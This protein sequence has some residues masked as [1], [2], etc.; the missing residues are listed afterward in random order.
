[1]NNLEYL[2]ITKTKFSSEFLCTFLGGLTNLTVL[3][4]RNCKISDRVVEIITEN[5]FKL[6]CLDL[7][8]YSNVEISMDNLKRIGTNLKNL[9]SLTLHSIKYDNSDDYK[10]ILKSIINNLI[11]LEYLKISFSV[12]DDEDLIRN[13]EGF[14]EINTFDSSRNYF[15]DK[16]ISEK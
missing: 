10:E 5:L 12:F 2:D 15:T 3:K 16:W 6:T 7:D 13:C 8:H 14:K 9:T 1:M 11:N 4:A